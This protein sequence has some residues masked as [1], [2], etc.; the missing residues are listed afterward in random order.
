MLLTFNNSLSN[1]AYGGAGKVSVMRFNPLAWT[2]CFAEDSCCFDGSNSNP[3]N[4][5]IAGGNWNNDATNVGSRNRNW[6]NVNNRNT[7]IAARGSILEG[8]ETRFRLT[9]G[10]AHDYKP[11]QAE[12]TPLHATYARIGKMA[13]GRRS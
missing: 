2:L 11:Y 10:T 6:N 9:S 4:R 1:P 8:P 13:R 7:N 5:V 12:R 3:G